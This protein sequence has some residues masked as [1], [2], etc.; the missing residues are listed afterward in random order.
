MGSY[1]SLLNIAF[2]PKARLTIDIMGQ[3]TS[4][5]HTY[6]R[7]AHRKSAWTALACGAALMSDGSLPTLV[8]FGE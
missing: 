6:G 2:P 8:G 5:F 1:V 7:G 4:R 3:K